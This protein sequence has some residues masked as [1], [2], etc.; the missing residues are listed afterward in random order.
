MYRR[1]DTRTPR[2]RFSA[3]V[4][5]ELDLRMNEQSWSV[6]DFIRE[7][8]IS[9]PTM[10]VWL[11]PNSERMP[12]VKLVKRYTEQ[13]RIPFEPYAEALGWTESLAAPPADLEGFIRRAQ[14]LA[15]HPKT[16]ERR[17]A[18]LEDQIRQAESA[19]QAARD[20]KKIA[21]DRLK[22]TL[23]DPEGANDR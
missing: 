17:R 8:G 18:E 21:E 16:S 3:L 2:Q 19:L 6:S 23:D 15:D 7:S 20:I 11:D 13:L 12:S 10:Y 9:R 4:Q 5:A 1:Q 22:K 14:G